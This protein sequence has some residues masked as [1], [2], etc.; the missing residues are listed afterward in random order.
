MIIHKDK[1]PRRHDL[2]SV[3]HINPDEAGLF[4]LHLEEPLFPNWS[5][6]DN[7]PPDDLMI[8]LDGGV[9][10]EATIHSATFDVDGDGYKAEVIGTPPDSPSHSV[11]T[12][13]FVVKS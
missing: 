12:V 9:S 1:L 13:R 4:D 7:L 2:D 11:W 10:S 5:G 8:L 3:V 6:S